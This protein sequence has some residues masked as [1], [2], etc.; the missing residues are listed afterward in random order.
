ME[1]VSYIKNLIMFQRA[2]DLIEVLNSGW[3]PNCE[4]GWPIRLAARYGCYY[5][6]ET[7]IQNGAN[8]HLV[9]DSGKYLQLHLLVQHSL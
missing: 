3:D 8:P 4:G 1:R 9:S 6:V 7:L 5:I 2:K